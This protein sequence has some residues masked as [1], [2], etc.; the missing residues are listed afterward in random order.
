MTNR[1]HAAAQKLSASIPRGLGGVIQV[2]QLFLESSWWKAEACMI[3]AWHALSVAVREAQ[4]IGML[5]IF[6]D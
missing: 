4:E 5:M 2:Q 1:F 6:T 3:D